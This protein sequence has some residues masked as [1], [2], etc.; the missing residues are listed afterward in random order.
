[1]RG[2][3][4]VYWDRVVGIISRR[5]IARPRLK[6]F[7]LAAVL[8]APSRQQGHQLSTVGDEELTRV[9]TASSKWAR[10]RAYKFLDSTDRT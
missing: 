4:Q 2:F 7:Y 1:M 10:H 6:T 8:C 9:S 3:V 5:G